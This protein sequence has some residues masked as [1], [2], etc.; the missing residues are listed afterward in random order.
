VRIA[1]FIHGDR[2]T[3]ARSEGLTRFAPRPIH[4]PSCSRTGPL[5]GAGD[6]TL[7]IGGSGDTANGETG[8]DVIFE[9]DAVPGEDEIDGGPGADKWIVEGTSAVSVQDRGA[10]ASVFRDFPFKS[11]PVAEEAVRNVETFEG[12][13][14]ADALSGALRRLRSGGTHGYD[15]R[16]GPDV[17]VGSGRADRLRGGNGRDVL[18]GRGGDDDL[19]AKSGERSAVPDELIDCGS[20]GADSARIDLLD[21]DP[22]GCETVARS[23]IP[24]GPHVRIG[25]IRRVR[26]R[27]YSV[28]LSCPDKLK[29]PCRGTLE[30]ALTRR[31]LRPARGRRYSIRAGRRRTLRV[32]L[33]RRD[34]RKLRGLRRASGFVRSTEKGD[35][36]GKKT[37][38]ARRRLKR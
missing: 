17:I 13:N 16:G 6:D 34:A 20:G 4:G 19:D 38:L 32:R 7:H 18:Q 14:V 8:A 1:A 23:A 15:G 9:E 27:T 36:A 30:L 37:T 3:S 12:T 5:G 33:T 26:G 11:Q 35:V 22:T 10:A 21:P 24:E 28:R 25:A 29:H 2:P 31:G